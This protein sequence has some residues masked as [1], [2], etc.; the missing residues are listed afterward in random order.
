MRE[1]KQS[2]SPS[3]YDRE[4]GAT[5]GRDVEPK[6]PVFNTIAHQEA[7]VRRLAD[8]RHERRLQALLPT[9]ETKLVED[10]G[11]WVAL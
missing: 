1:P 9:A 7:T 2:D 8:E 11:T 5:T 6:W 3:G 10:F 4:V